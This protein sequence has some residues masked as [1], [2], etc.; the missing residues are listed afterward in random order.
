MAG[1]PGGFMRALFPAFVL[2]ALPVL[3]APTQPAHAPDSRDPTNLPGLTDAHYHL[4]GVGERELTL[5]LDSARSLDE[6]QSQLTAWAAAHPDAEWIT[7]RGWIETHFDPPVFPT[8]HDLDAVVPERPVYLTRADGHAGVANSRALEIASIRGDTEAPF[9]GEILKDAEGEPT[10]MLIDR[11]QRLVRQH[12]PDDGRPDVR[13]ALRVGGEV[14]ARQGWATLHTIVDGWAEVEALRAL[15]LEELMPVRNYVAVR[16]PG[17]GAEFLL[18]HGPIVGEF[19]G[20]LTIR[21]IKINLDGALGSRGAALLDPYHDDPG[22]CGLLT[23]TPE[24]LAPVLERALRNGIQVWTHAIGDRANRLALDLYEE[25]FASVPAADRA[26]EQ[27][28]WRIEH[29]QHLTAADIPRFA[30]LGVIASMQPSHAIGDLHF[31]PRRLGLERL[32]YA[33]A[34]RD[35][36][37]AGAIVVGG[38]DA[39]VEVG[40]PRIEFHAATTRTDLDGYSGQGWHPEQAVSWAEAVKMFTSWAAYAAFEEDRIGGR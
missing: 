5:N 24:E 2:F 30:A 13:T 7:G 34:W 33:Y 32:R 4:R 10:G 14:A 23:H 1:T 40:D 11:A 25:A 6:L 39:P 38:S 3:A 20:R 9:G 31:A 12:I 18:D 35:L 22:N 26:V 29:A 37:D 15:Y 19:D 17:E 16:W 8:R 21:A 27:P 28:R 36:I